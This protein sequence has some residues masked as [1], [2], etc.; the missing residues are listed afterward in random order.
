MVQRE[1]PP[2]R[3]TRSFAGIP[4]LYV[5]DRGGRIRFHM[6]GFDAEHFQEHV[7]LVD[8]SQPAPYGRRVRLEKGQGMGALS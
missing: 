5:I 4:Q 6:V 2:G 7:K 3:V 1:G 8:T